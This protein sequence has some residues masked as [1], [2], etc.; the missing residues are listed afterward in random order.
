MEAVDGMA[1][2]DKVA[3][4]YDEWVSQSVGDESFY[5]DLAKNARGRVLEVGCGTGR[6]YLPMLK[7][8]VDAYGFDI[9]SKMLVKLKEKAAKEGLTPKVF[10]ADMRN[11]R[12]GKKFKLII[13]P[14]L[15]FTHLP[16]SED[17]LAALKTIRAHLAPNGKF[18]LDFFCP[19]S[20]FISKNYGKWVKE[21]VRNTTGRTFSYYSDE[22]N[23]TVTSL[24]EISAGG[25]KYSTKNQ[26]TLIYKKEFELLLRLAGFSKWKVYGGFKREPLNSVRQKMVWIVEK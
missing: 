23:Q 11:F 6:I 21:K 1:E 7:S 25:K 8:G 15:S 3:K 9:S 19:S 12:A 10:R 26:F 4:I 22:V 16:V 13:V 17:Q 20:E 18:A 24:R 2:F 14:F 5:L